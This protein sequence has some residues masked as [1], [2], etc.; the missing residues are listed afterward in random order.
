MHECKHNMSAPVDMGG[1]GLETEVAGVRSRSGS[2]CCRFSYIDAANQE[3]HK[4]IISERQHASCCEIDLLG[5]STSCSRGALQTR[6]ILGQ[7]R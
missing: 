6:V 1:L 4:T 7:S 5:I 3:Q 2:S